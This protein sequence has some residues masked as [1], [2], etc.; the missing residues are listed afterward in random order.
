MWYTIALGVISLLILWLKPSIA[1]FAVLG[2]LLFYIAGNGIIHVRS[3]NVSKDII[4]EYSL[5]A[6]VVFF[7]LV[8]AVLQSL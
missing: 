8:G 7:V 6:L 1:L 2:M 4:I 5:V 3:K